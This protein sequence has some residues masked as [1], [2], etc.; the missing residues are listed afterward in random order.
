[1]KTWT[2]IGLALIGL[3]LLVGIG[4]QVGASGATHSD[5]NQVPISA[6]AERGEELYNSP[7]PAMSATPKTARV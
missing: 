5:P 4:S 7:C 6:W 1:M 3:V 2:T